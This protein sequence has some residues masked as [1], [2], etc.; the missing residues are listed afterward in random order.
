VITAK[1][2]ARRRAA[3]VGVAAAALVLILA[4][5][6]FLLTLTPGS[7]SKISSAVQ[8]SETSGSST[9]TTLQPTSSSQ[10]TTLQ[11]SSSE[12]L[13]T[14]VQS[15]TLT[16]NSVVSTSSLESVVQSQTTTT[17]SPNSPALLPT[18]FGNVSS[19]SSVVSLF[20]SYSSMSV[21]FSEASTG[22]AYVSQTFT[23]YDTS[24]E[25][26]SSVSTNYSLL[27]TS[28][29]TYK[30]AITESQGESGLNATAWVLR[31]GTAVAY[32]YLGQNITGPEA[33][34]LF[35]GLM[36]PF[37]FEVESSLLVQTLTPSNNTLTAGQTMGRLGSATVSL[38]NYTAESLPVTIPICGGSLTLSRDTVQ[39]GMV[40]SGVEPLLASLSI[41]GSETYFG[42]TNQIISLSFKLNSLKTV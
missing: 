38:V 40:R 42:I 29:T 9:S 19:S 39:L 12:S 26:V 15:F 28:S 2:F 6:Y 13:A 24:V 27:Y 10:S 41:A 8:N 34:G 17:C 11:A 3:Q 23:S 18:A 33:T 30:V 35:D 25:G 31:S 7:S 36:T 20:G 37:F 4:G 21:T 14:G 32:D 22:I 1:S 16:S 5:S